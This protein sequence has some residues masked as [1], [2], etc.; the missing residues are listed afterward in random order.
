MALAQPAMPAMALP[1]MSLAAKP[2]SATSA[3]MAQVLASHGI[4]S[5][6]APIAPSVPFTAPAPLE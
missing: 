5:T 6:N 4:K 2:S 1:T 3:I